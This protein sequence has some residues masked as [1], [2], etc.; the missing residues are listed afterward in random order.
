MNKI[1]AA[2]N[3]LAVVHLI[4]YTGIISLLCS[5][6]KQRKDPAPSESEET[7]TAVVASGQ[8]ERVSSTPGNTYSEAPTKKLGDNPLV[9]TAIDTATSTDSA[10]DSGTFIDFSPTGFTLAAR[11]STA[12]HLTWI[13]SSK[14]SGYM[15]IA[16]P[17][18]A[19]SFTPADGTIHSAGAHG[20]DIIV[21]HRHNV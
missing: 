18:S 9:G 2:F 17:E 16:R 4:T 13:S 10:Q 5:C 12:I 8:P 19:V 14:A 11:S 3:R 1:L 21:C 6:D 20:S 15:L 7:T